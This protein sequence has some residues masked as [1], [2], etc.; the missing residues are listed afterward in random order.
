MPITAEQ[1]EILLEEMADTPYSAPTSRYFKTKEEFDE[2]VGLDFIEQAN[3]VT[4]S[5]QKFVVGLSHGISPSGVY[6]YILEH[7]KKLWYPELIRYTFVNSKLQRQRG[8]KDVTDAIG[9]LKKLLADGLI[10]KDQI[11]GRS[12]DRNNMQA[13]ADGLNEKLAQYLK[14]EGKTGLDFVF[15]ASDP[16]GRVAGITRDS[17]AFG[18]TKLGMVVEAD[19]EKELTLTPQF[20]LKSQRI[21]FLVTKQDKRRALAWLFYREGRP[22][23]SPGF[24]RFMPEV[25]ERMTVYVDD[26][27]LTW[28]QIAITRETQYGPTKI[29]IDLA[30]PYENDPEDKRPV[31]LLLHGFLGLNTFDGLLTAIPTSKYIAAAM[32]YGS[33][34]NDLPPVRYSRFIVNNLN[35]VID[36]FGSKGHPVYL[37]DHSM[38]NIYFMMMDKMWPELD[39]TQ[40]YLRGRIGANPFFGEEAKHALLG[41][42]D[43]V[44][45]KSE[46]GPIERAIFLAARNII[47]WDSRRGVRTRGIALSNW[48]IGKESSMR[49]RIWVSIK[50]R[51]LHLMSN[52]GSLPHLN[53]IPIERALSRLPAKVFAIQTHSALE[54]SKQFDRNKNLDNIKKAGV[55]ILILKSER[56]SVARFVP[57]YYDD[58]S[59]QIIDVTNDNESDKFREHLYHMINPKDTTLIIDRFIQENP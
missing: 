17:E 50:A 15:I 21:A 6:E 12:L 13:Y 20:L 4:S 35:A 25:E 44:I 23:K 27:A 28:P 31:I 48:L 56:D 19:G 26:K 38:G 51:I 42:M 46:Q 41:F 32:H 47:P 53:R 33:I 14:D 11:L 45:L 5:G 49:D 43:N 7:F 40:K 30:L 55:P 3:K 2:A 10:E 37:F 59:V 24:L 57:K 22:D 34:P 52:L 36:Y 16:T 54:E 58:P 39:A 8:L 9:F 18:S 1:T 29:K